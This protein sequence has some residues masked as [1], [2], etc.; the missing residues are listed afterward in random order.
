MDLQKVENGQK[1]PVSLQ[2][3]PEGLYYL[4]A[5]SLLTESEMT[6]E[7]LLAVVHPHGEHAIK[8]RLNSLNEETN[9]RKS[10][11]EA[12]RKIDNIS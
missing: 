12:L 3:V 10:L 5:D 2:G 9:T 1:F 4:T 7:E 8:A 11:L 6:K